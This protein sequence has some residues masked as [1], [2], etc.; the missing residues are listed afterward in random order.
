MSEE[1]KGISNK[2]DLTNMINDLGRLNYEEGAKD[3]AITLGLAGL[4][5]AAVRKVYTIWKK[6]KMT[7]KYGLTFDE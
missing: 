3:A 7:E 1:K 5:Y 4:A 2:K 6:K